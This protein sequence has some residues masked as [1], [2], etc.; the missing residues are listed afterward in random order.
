MAKGNQKKTAERGYGSE[1]RRMRESLRPVI[2]R[3]DGWCMAAVCIMPSR[4]IAPGSRWDLGHLP[5]RSGWLGACHQACNRSEGGRRGNAHWPKAT[6]ARERR[7]QATE[8]W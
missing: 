4:W 7:W 6:K 8:D 5:D 1:H 3:G 2:E